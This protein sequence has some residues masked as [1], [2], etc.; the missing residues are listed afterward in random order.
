[1]DRGDDFRAWQLYKEAATKGEGSKDELNW[2]AAI[3]AVNYAQKQVDPNEARRA[4]DEAL[5]LA[6]DYGDAD[7]ELAVLALHQSQIEEAQTYF[8]AGIA[9]WKRRRD[10][11]GLS[12]EDRDQAN[13][14]LQAMQQS[15]ASALVLDGQKHAAAGELEIA[16]KRFEDAVRAAPPGSHVYNEAGE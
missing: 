11:S 12:Q 15:E 9:A 7:N 14:E 5:T 16:R 2:S 3:C 4:C 8:D 6:P 1:A 10:R 13:R